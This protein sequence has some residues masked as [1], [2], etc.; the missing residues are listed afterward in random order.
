MDGVESRLLSTYL[1]LKNVAGQLIRRNQ[2]HEPLD[3]GCVDAWV[4]NAER[5]LSELG[6]PMGTLAKEDE[7][8][9]SQIVDY[10]DLLLASLYRV[11]EAP[12]PKIPDIV[13]FE[14]GAKRSADADGHSFDIISP[15]G[16]ERLAKVYNEGARKYG[17][18]NWEKG[19]P[20]GA[21]L[22]HALRHLNMWQQGDQSEDHLAKVAWG[23]FAIMH[24]EKTK[25]E[26][27]ERY[28]KEGI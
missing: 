13:T 10:R 14:T 12:A 11:E 23:L 4:S 6:S 24:F 1:E 9:Y 17:A 15:I 19:Q 20:V 3:K 27:L 2:S 16:L 25:P 21:V 22:N 26:S 18:R 5:Y 8:K 7:R 28:F